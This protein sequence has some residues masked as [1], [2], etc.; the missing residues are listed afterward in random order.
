MEKE[1]TLQAPYEE[2]Q[3]YVHALSGFSTSQTLKLISYIKHHKVIVLID[4]DST[5]NFIHRR[6]T[7]ET[8][9]YVH[10]IPIFKI[11]IANGGIVTLKIASPNYLRGVEPLSLVMSS[12]SNFSSLL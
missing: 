5:H 4:S 11:M 10:A 8:H 9:C 12:R 3:I 7:E 2:P 6:V 1:T